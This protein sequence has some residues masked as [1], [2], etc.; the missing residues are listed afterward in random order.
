MKKWTPACS[1]L[2]AEA[3]MTLAAVESSKG[4]AE[5]SRMKLRRWSEMRSRMVPTVD[6]APKKKAP[7]RR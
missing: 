5:Q 7:L 2:R 6:A 3:S 4:T 1:A